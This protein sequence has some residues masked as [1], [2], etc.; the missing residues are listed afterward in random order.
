M[1]ELDFDFL[2]ERLS[3]EA[4][5]ILSASI[6]ESRQRNHNF[7]SEDHILLALCKKERKLLQDTICRH[8]LKIE[9]FTAETQTLLDSTKP[10]VGR[11][12]KMTPEL[13]RTLRTAWKGVSETEQRVIET[14]DLLDAIQKNGTAAAWGFIQETGLP[15]DEFHKS[16]DEYKRYYFENKKW[17]VPEDL[18]F[19]PP[20]HKIKP[21]SHKT[22]QSRLLVYGSILILFILIA[23]VLLLC[24]SGLIKAL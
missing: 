7:L 18:N 13:K 1:R 23:L 20:R 6:E 16:L 10:Y 11:S 12:F 21:Q 19:E 22:K 8:A 2:R 3:P 4:M 24:L 17:N 15:S 5:Q 14:F 9:D